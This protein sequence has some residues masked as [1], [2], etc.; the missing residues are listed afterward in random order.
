MELVSENDGGT[1]FF[2]L[3]G[4]GEGLDS[5]V[6]PLPPGGDASSRVRH[7]EFVRDTAGKLVEMLL[8]PGIDGA[9]DVGGTITADV[10]QV[11]AVHMVAEAARE[12]AK[13]A[14]RVFGTFGAQIGCNSAYDAGN[15]G[16]SGGGLWAILHCIVGYVV[17][18]QIGGDQ[19]NHK[20]GVIRPR[21][22]WD[23]ACQEGIM[24]AQKRRHG[25]NLFRCP[26]KGLQVL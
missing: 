25:N 7:R 2:S 22:T 11:E 5:I 19:S 1:F 16:M 4:C 24:K 15:L 10:V 23:V 20:L 21:I 3:G 13:D 17:K 14:F 8:Q 9:L 12:A 26:M 18:V 6:R